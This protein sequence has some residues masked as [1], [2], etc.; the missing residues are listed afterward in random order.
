MTENQQEWNKEYKNLKRRVKSWVKKFHAVVELPQKPERIYKKDIERLKQTT[1]KNISET[2]K[3]QAR[4]EYEYRYENK[5]P[6]VYIPKPAYTPP[7]EQDYFN[8]PDYGEDYDR[9][10]EEQHP[11][12]EEPDEDG[13]TETVISRDEIE[14][15]ID[16]NINTITVE[17]E[18][19]GV[20]EQLNN[21]VLEAADA[22][23]DY[24]TYL[25]YLEQNAIILNEL[26]Q[27]AI[28]G[29]IGKNGKIYQEDPQALAKFATVLN[30]KRPLTMSQSERLENE[31]WVSY[32]F[33]D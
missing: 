15:W 25:N 3:K 6:E 29:Y 16:A 33:N 23:G 1:W 8:N 24:E 14:A 5:I 17:R 20:R 31:G 11:G 26:A 9:E 4:K 27:K 30:L 12:W 19:D 10:W 28:S 22:F 32:D 7:T 2:E 21:L 13:Y 18:L